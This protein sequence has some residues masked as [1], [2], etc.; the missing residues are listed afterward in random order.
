MFSKFVFLLLPWVI[1]YPGLRFFPFHCFTLYIFS[2]F[3]VYVSTR[4]CFPATAMFSSC[5][6]LLMFSF[7]ILFC[8]NYFNSCL[9]VCMLPEI[10]TWFSVYCCVNFKLFACFSK[11]ILVKYT[12]LNQYPSVCINLN[13]TYFPSIL[14]YTFLVRLLV[15]LLEENVR[16]YTFTA[17]SQSTFC[18]Q[19]ILHT[20]EFILKLL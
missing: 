20:E 19:S 9:A 12:Q 1:L 13:I 16:T 7:V 4:N 11:W 18:L 5:R 14:S 10:Y 3:L 2:F 8:Y 6:S 15:S 17:N